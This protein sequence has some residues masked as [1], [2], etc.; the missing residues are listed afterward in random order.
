MATISEQRRENDNRKLAWKPNKAISFI[1]LD[2]PEIPASLYEDGQLRNFK[3]EGWLPTGLVSSEGYTFAREVN[4]EEVTAL[5]YTSPILNP[6]TTVPRTISFTPF[7]NVRKHLLAIALGTSL[8]DVPMDPATGEVVIDEPDMPV[9]FTFAFLVLG[10][11]GPAD[12]HFVRGKGYPS[13]QLQGTAE[14]VWGSEGTN[15]QEWTLDVYAG[16]EEGIPVRH[17]FGGTGMVA[18]KDVI[19]FDPAPTG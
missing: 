10:E 9:D 17:Y 4:R 12:E 13:V 1:K 15:A 2:D 14:E 16:E 8:D 7:E 11:S 19:G 6:V 5:G 18:H 3:S